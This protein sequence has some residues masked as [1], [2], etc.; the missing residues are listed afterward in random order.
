[1]KYFST[2]LLI[3]FVS[4]GLSAPLFTL[5][6]VPVTEAI[7]VNPSVCPLNQYKIINA[8]NSNANCVTLTTNSF[9]NGA[10]WSCNS[11]NLV[12]SFKT[13]FEINFGSNINTGDGMV[14]L[15]Q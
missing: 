5:D 9:Q 7:G 14:F 10:I 2:I 6:N 8:A 4:V 1:M 3:V 11:L 12:Q 15:L 13:N